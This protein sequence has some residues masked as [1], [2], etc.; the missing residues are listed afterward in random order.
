MTFYPDSSGFTIRAEPDNLLEQETLLKWF[1]GEIALHM[2]ESGWIENA[3]R[4]LGLRF[5]TKAKE[6]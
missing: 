4:L 2:Q 5:Q 1:R 3:D 6:A